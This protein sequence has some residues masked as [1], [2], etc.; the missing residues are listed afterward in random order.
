[1]RTPNVESSTQPTSAAGAQP[2]SARA[3]PPSNGFRE[4]LEHGATKR[5]FA[6]TPEKRA[7]HDARDEALAGTKSRT[8][9]HGSHRAGGEPP[10][11]ADPAAAPTAS[12]A[13]GQERATSGAERRASLT[14]EAGARTV[15]DRRAAHRERDEGPRPADGATFT[16]LP[17]VL[18]PP[19]AAVTA[20]PVSPR[21]A[22][23]EIAALADRLLR[24]LRV[25]RLADGTSMVRLQL[26]GGGRGDVHVE[27]RQTEAGLAAVVTSAD[28]DRAR[29]SEWAD[30]LSAALG[31]R[32]LDLR[33]I[34]L[35]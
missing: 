7:G 12:T 33:S 10:R 2:A 19:S 28:G 20:A 24:S 26:D 14:D 21:T 31:A 15:R 4:C 32:G 3:R 9:V 25:G 8:P 16:P 29:A 17:T 18:L 30:R 13:A 22:P 6:P 5:R 11:P 1:M 27:L 34:E 35:G 23:A